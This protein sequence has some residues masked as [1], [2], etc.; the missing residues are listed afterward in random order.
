SIVAPS[1]AIA[2]TCSRVRL[3][4]SRVM[5]PRSFMRNYL[6]TFQEP[7]VSK[8]PTSFPHKRE[9]IVLLLIH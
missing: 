6:E 5:V 1:R 7:D 2:I 3:L 9:S 4:P 8:I